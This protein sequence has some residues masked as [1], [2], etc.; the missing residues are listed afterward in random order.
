[1]IIH[2]DWNGGTYQADLSQP[3]DISIPFRPDGV[4]A[5]Y[6]DPMSIAPFRMGDFVGSVE[7][8]GP[9]NFNDIRFNPHAH[10]THTECVGHITR[11]FRS[12]S[13]Q[14][15]PVF[16]LAHLISIVPK[17]LNGD[18]VISD[19]LLRDVLPLVH[20][21][22]LIVRTRPHD[23]TKR[24]RNYTGTNFPYLT[25][26]AMQLIVSRGVSHLLVDLP[27]VDREED[28]GALLAHR[29][30]WDGENRTGCTITEFIHAD[31]GIADGLYLLNLQVAPFENDAAPSRPLIFKIEPND[32]SD[33]V[34]SEK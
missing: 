1:M 23:A 27:S 20:A 31:E 26:E 10:G 3:L 30:F 4:R 2:F 25:R 18:R 22:G 14:M 11:E 6:A 9:V 24:T 7:K 29:A 16:C 19:D 5:W 12:V 34:G 8:G 33:I 21:P 32:H 28:G 13:A 15:P 17:E